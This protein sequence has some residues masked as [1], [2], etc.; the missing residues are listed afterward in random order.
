MRWW[1]GIWLNEAFATFMEV[2][3]CEAYR[4]D[5]E[6]WTSFGIERTA[7]FEVDGLDSTRTVEFEVR[8]PADAD[9][10]FDVL[11]YQKG[12]ALLRMLEQYLGEDRFREGVSHYLRTHA[13]GN[14]ETNDLWDAIEATSGS[15]VR[16]IMDSWIWQPGYPLV[17][18]SL[19]DDEG[20]PGLHLRQR[21]F[22]LNADTQQDDTARW[23]IPIQIRNG[24]TTTIILLDGAETITALAEPDAPV[25]VN[26]G[27]S[28]FYRVSYDDALRRRLDGDVLAELTTSERYNL[29]DDAW[30]ATV[31][32]QLS[33]S[34]MLEFLDVFAEEREHAVWQAIVSSL[35]GLNR[36]LDD[37]PAHDAFQGRVRALVG[38][39]LTRLGEPRAG[40]AGL[41]GTLRGMLT[42]ALGVLGDD[43]GIQARSRELFD[44]VSAD[45]TSVDPEL[46]A[47]ATSVVAAT[48]DVDTFD[49][50]R[51]GFSTAATPQEKLRNLYALA[52]FGDEELVLATCEFAMT[53]AVK[54]QNAPFLLH[55][56][57][58]NRRHGHVAW[59]FVCDHWNAANERFPA[60]TI[61]RMVDSVKLLNTPEL[62]ADAAAFFASHPIDQGAKTLDQ[63][64]ER[65]R[66][67]A[68][69]RAREGRRFADFLAP[70]GS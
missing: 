60:N 62:V 21:R 47:A 29:V 37:G 45:P 20:R 13:Y 7:A 48:G 63:I 16:R 39:A 17:C 11:T 25:V 68:S 2:A 32:G 56:A 8:S 42:G 36:L 54:T 24:A 65:Q 58:A 34:E 41:I 33:A 55:R 64:L 26:A 40:E 61:V 1:N 49:R 67:N 10:M 30:A 35:R 57:I 23:A 66:V 51:E 18:A 69:L 28:G 12:G 19:V 9:G 43:A 5:W 14:T 59:A 44:A 6:R 3:A 53:S 50:M 46:A 22:R 52:D 70:S 38:P 31:S 15:P 27:G 4:P